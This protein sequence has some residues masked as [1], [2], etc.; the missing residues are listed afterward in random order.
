MKFV[1]RDFYAA[2]SIRRCAELNT[3]PAELRRS[4][5]LGQLL[6]LELCK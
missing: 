3:R 5:F 2:I 4:N 1:N 6:M